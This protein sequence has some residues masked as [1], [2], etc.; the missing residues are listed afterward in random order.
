MLEFVSYTD[1]R[2]VLVKVN[3]DALKIA[4]AIVGKAILSANEEVIGHG[5]I[6]ASTDCPPTERAVPI[7]ARSDVDFCARCRPS[8]CGIDKGAIERIA[9]TSTQR[10]GPI[11]AYVAPHAGDAVIV[12]IPVVI[13]I[14][15]GADDEVI[16]REIVTDE[17]P[18]E[19]TVEILVYACA[20]DAEFAV[21]PRASS[22]NTDIGT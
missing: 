5:V 1:R 4:V 18:D 22:L 3:I 13:D 20:G 16:E 6:D 10:S 17:L 14:A 15:L 19:S 21:E 12:V 2:S 9:H 8:A 11:G 7:F